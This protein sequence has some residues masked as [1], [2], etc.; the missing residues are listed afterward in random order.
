MCVVG[1]YNRLYLK[2][3]LKKKN[4]IYIRSTI[5]EITKVQYCLPYIDKKMIY[6]AC[7]ISTINKVKLYIPT[8]QITYSTCEPKCLIQWP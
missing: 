3:C 7:T 5:S 1:F 4:L 8:N 6:F 2:K